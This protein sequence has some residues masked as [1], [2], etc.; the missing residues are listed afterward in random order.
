M[1]EQ[2]EPV[3][4]IFLLHRVV[5]THYPDPCC[6]RTSLFF[7]LL[8]PVYSLILFSSSVKPKS[9]WALLKPH[10]ENLFT[11]F[12]FPKVGFTESKA[13]LWE[14]DQVDYVRL[15]V[16]GS[17]PLYSMLVDF[18]MRVFLLVFFANMH[19]SLFCRTDHFSSDEYESFSTPGAAATTFVISLVSNRTK[20]TF[21]PI[22]GY[23][24]GVLRRFGHLLPTFWTAF[25]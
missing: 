22:L 24:N 18:S 23:I 13:A 9:T 2:E 14:T 5:S 11:Q 16:G 20:T 21:G 17:T 25:S 7:F 3:F 8:I 12:V 6:M 4:G 15:S 19:P 1:D 10:F